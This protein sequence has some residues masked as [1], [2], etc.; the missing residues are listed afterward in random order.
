MS[1]DL[2]NRGPVDRSK[3]NLSEK[4]EVR[5]WSKQLGV[6]EL[7]LRDAVKVAGSS[8]ENVKQKLGK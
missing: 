4:H 5:Y 3:I 7:Q 8:V 1:D 2:N 6:T